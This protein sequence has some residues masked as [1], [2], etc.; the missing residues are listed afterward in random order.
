MLD[1]DLV[2]VIRIIF[3]IMSSPYQVIVQLP[4]VEMMH[5]FLMQ[6]Y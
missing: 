5:Q 6:T 1:L 2:I 3:Y 4:V